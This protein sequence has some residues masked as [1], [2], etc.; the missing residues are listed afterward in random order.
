MQLH[1]SASAP[2]LDMSEDPAV[3]LL[4][5]PAPTESASALGLAGTSGSLGGRIGAEA[6]WHLRLSSL[7]AGGSEPGVKYGIASALFS[8]SQGWETHGGNPGLVAPRRREVKEP[9][10]AAV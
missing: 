9:R 3:T 2:L 5:R 4:A 1:S 7:A 10:G 8:G 6:A